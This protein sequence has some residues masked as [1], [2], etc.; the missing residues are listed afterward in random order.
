MVQ[1]TDLFVPQLLGYHR[2]RKGK[3]KQEITFV[4]HLSA[5]HII[6]QWLGSR[7]QW[8]PVKAPFAHCFSPTQYKKKKKDS[9]TV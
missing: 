3:Q 1:V 5:K 9:G 6:M 7:T 2:G 8:L 4:V